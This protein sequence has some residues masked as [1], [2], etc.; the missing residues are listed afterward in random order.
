MQR[1]VIGTGRCGSTLLSTLLAEHPRALV[2]SEFFGGLDFVNGLRD[3][4]VSGEELAAILLRDHEI[5][6]LNRSRAKVDREILLDLKAYGSPRIPVLLLV[7]LPALTNDPN[8]LMREIVLWARAQKTRT[9][10]E[11]YPNL[12]DW[13]TILFKKDFWIERS[14][15]SSEF[16]PGLRSLFPRA[17]YLHIHRDGEETALSMRQQHHFITHVS[18][19]FDPPSDEE[20]ARVIRGDDPPGTDLIAQRER[21]RASPEQFGLFWTM[22]ICRL[23]SQLPHLARDQ[24]HEVRFED[25]HADPRAFLKTACEFFQISSEDEWMDRAIAKMRPEKNQRSGELTQP[26]R[27][28]LRAAVFP[29]QVLLKREGQLRPN[30]PLYS[31]VRKLWDELQPEIAFKMTDG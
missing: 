30:L 26:E 28:R 11:H 31:R 9:L 8:G 24:Y 15:A 16:F 23:Y 22:S 29:G 20:V 21:N 19:Y 14:G 1:F 18:F 13:M 10:H 5:S 3:G 27:E 17:H 25:L 12:F 7:C 4:P 6:N 2:L